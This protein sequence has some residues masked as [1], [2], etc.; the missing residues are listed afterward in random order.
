MSW[1]AIIVDNSPTRTD[2][3]AKALERFGLAVSP[4]RE[5]QIT[6]LPGAGDRQVRHDPEQSLAAIHD[7]IRTRRR[8]DLLVL[9]VHYPEDDWAGLDVVY[10]ELRQKYSTPDT[11]RHVAIFSSYPG[12]E[13]WNPRR[14]EFFER[15]D[16]IAQ[17][18]SR[19]SRRATF[20]SMHQ[21]DLERFGEW[22]NGLPQAS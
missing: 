16:G 2:E 13:S 12:L 19:V 1:T 3:R 7:C 4:I 18:D 8:I 15:V 21:R 14:K 11:W 17:L 6:C 9:D 5:W 20:V 10:P 22:A